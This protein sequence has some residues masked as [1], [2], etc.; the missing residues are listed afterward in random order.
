MIKQG[1]TPDKLFAVLAELDELDEQFMIEL[2]GTPEAGKTTFKSMLNAG[3][4]NEYKTRSLSE[5]A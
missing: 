3:L 2:L 1:H 5:S 4:P